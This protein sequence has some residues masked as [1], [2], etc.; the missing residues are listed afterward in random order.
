MLNTSRKETRLSKKIHAGCLSTHL[1]TNGPKSKRMRSKTMSLSLLRQ[2]LSERKD[3]P[4]G[5]SLL[6]QDLRHMLNRWTLPMCN[7]KSSKCLQSN[8]KE[9]GN[10]VPIMQSWS[11]IG[12]WWLLKK[13]WRRTQRLRGI[14]QS[15]LSWACK[16]SELFRDRMQVDQKQV[17]SSSSWQSSVSTEKFPQKQESRSRF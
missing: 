11:V 1:R 3:R 7:K 15:N 17:N 5:S 2:A 12:L 13:T 16:K 6:V 4:A 8:L 10:T 14:A 9:Q